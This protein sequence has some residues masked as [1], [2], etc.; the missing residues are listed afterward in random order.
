MTSFVFIG[1][2][3]GHFI[4]AKRSDYEARHNSDNHIDTRL[5]G[6]QWMNSDRKESNA[7]PRD[8]PISATLIVPG[9]SSRIISIRYSQHRIIDSGQKTGQ[10]GRNFE[11][12]WLTRSS[13]GWIGGALG[14]WVITLNVNMSSSSTW[15]RRRQ[16]GEG[17]E[18][19][20]SLAKIPTNSPL[21]RS[22]EP[23]A[24]RTFIFMSPSEFFNGLYGGMNNQRVAAEFSDSWKRKLL[25]RSFS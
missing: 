18:T 23:N 4:V 11:R 25:R 8:D 10:G 12:P 5:L 9:H 20:L 6:H 13:A 15:R 22:T 17:K 24:S 1:I 2:H 3:R 16:R 7:G 21:N 14:Y 19:V